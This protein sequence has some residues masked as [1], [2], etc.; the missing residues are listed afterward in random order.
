M[1][2]NSPWV[3]LWAASGLVQAGGLCM[4]LWRWWCAGTVPWRTF[5]LAFLFNWTFT[6][7]HHT[8]WGIALDPEVLLTFLQGIMKLFAMLTEVAIMLIAIDLEQQ[9]VGTGPRSSMG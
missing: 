5:W 1:L 2:W 6:L 7:A 8:L 9:R 3:I 4:T